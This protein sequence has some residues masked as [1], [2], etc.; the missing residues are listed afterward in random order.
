MFQ[1]KFALLFI[2]TSLLT[3]ATS[4]ADAQHGLAIIEK[5]LASYWHLEM[6]KVQGKD[7]VED[8]IGENDGLVKGHPKIVEGKYGN[9]LEFNGINT[10][11]LVSANNLVGGNQP[12]TI[13]L[14]LF[15]KRAL[16]ASKFNGIVGFGNRAKAGQCL[17]VDVYNG[18][19]R[20]VNQIRMSHCL[21]GGAWDTVG[22]DMT[23]NEWHHVA[24]VYAGAKKSILYL[25][26]VEVATRELPAEPDVEI[27]TEFGGIIGGQNARRG[28]G[29]GL[30]EVTDIWEG[31][32]D[33]VGF[34]NRALTPGEVLRN[35]T[36]RQL[37]AVE[38]GGKLSLTWAKIQ[39]NRILIKSILRK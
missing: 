6:K 25:D 1:K 23:L 17:K 4:I 39:G 22:P 5:G 18:R 20:G 14:W 32:I 27:D 19:R 38:P 2:M 35:A 31:L 10:F 12:M 34:Y 7:F 8:I 37:F 13:S 29:G 24:A 9:A 15:A 11:I 28:D 33:E 26:G 3:F 21:H 30:Q 36:A 16:E